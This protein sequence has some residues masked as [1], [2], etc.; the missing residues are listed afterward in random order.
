MV[1]GIFLPLIVYILICLIDL[2]GFIYGIIGLGSRKK[3]K[4]VIGIILCLI[5]VIFCMIIIINNV[6]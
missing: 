2:A 1:G 5:V 4:A 3:Y 6:P